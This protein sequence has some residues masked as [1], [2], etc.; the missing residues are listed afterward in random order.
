MTALMIVSCAAQADEPRRTSQ[1]G[2]KT[3]SFTLN[4]L[5]KRPS[6]KTIAVPADP[7]YGGQ[8]KTYRAVPAAE[9][10]RGI[11]I[12]AGGTIFFKS[13]DGFS[14]PLNKSDLLN[15]DPQKSIGYVALEDPNQKWAPLKPGQTATAGPFYLVWQNPEKSN[16]AK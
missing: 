10:F 5:L 8:A 9:L 4:D 1:S 15:T 3:A 12:S 13:L 11:E 6:V 7:S 16:I 14:G 2:S